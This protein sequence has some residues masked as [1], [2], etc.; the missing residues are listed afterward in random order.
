MNVEPIS[1]RRPKLGYEGRNGFAE[2]PTEPEEIN[3]SNIYKAL[4]HHRRALYVINHKKYSVPRYV[5][6]PILMPNSNAS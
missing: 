6:A 5:F 1:I 4:D 3:D 2:R